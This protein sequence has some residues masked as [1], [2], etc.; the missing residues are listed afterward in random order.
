VPRTKKIFISDVH[1][2]AAGSASPPH[3]YGWLNANVPKLEGFLNEVLDAPDVSE[4]V[5]LGDLFDKWVLPPAVSPVVTFQDICDAPQ[6]KGIVEAL[7]QLSA[8]RDI[9]VSYVPGNHDMG[10]SLPDLSEARDFMEQQ[11]PGL[12]YISDHESPGGVYQSD[13]LAAEHGN[14]YCLFNAVDMVSNPASFLPIGYFMSRVE[15]YKVARH[16][17]GT[18]YHQIFDDFVHE[19]MNSENLVLDIF[20]ALVDDA[21]LR[22]SDTINTTG[23]PGFPD[24]LTIEAVG[25]MYKD[26]A[27]NWERGNKK[28]NY[29]TATLGDV[30]DLSLAADIMYF[31]IFGSAHNVVVFGHTHEATMKKHYLLGL[32]P[33]NLDAHVDIPCRAIYAN[34]GTWVD[35]GKFC[36][37]VETEKDEDLGRH[38]VRIW[39]YPDKVLLQKG[40]VNL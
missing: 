1:M 39:S 13:K 6:N 2:G 20:M 16:G 19:L 28:I 3:P 14:R 21:G 11:F 4:L 38:S 24:S 7:R 35:T 37:Y 15:A 29:I 31:S 8:K 9:V 27:H 33:Q 36:T 10:T 23:L 18:D 32:V 30:G 26:L 40:H 17:T 25:S 12:H 34:S 5:I 22:S